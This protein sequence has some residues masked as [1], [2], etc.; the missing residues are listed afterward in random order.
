MNRYTGPGGNLAR[1]IYKVTVCE[2]CGTTT[3]LRR[4]HK[5]RNRENNLP[6]NI[7]ILCQECHKAEH[8]S[9]GDW[10]RGQVKLVKCKICQNEFHPKRT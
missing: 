8:V 9:A 7:A 1:R 4:H 10:G 6:E 2:S 5:D 3:T